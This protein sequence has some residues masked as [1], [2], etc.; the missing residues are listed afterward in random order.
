MNRIALN[1]LKPADLATLNDASCLYSQYL[2]FF[3]LSE[4]GQPIFI[5]KSIAVELEYL[6]AG[7]LKVRRIPATSLLNLE[8]HQGFVLQN[9]LQHYIG[10]TK[11]DLER[12]RSY[13][14]LERINKMLPV[15][16]EVN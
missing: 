3:A 2:D 5:Y 12:A 15:V 6:I 10:K 11:D 9:A 7:R 1:K 16:P 4:P 8:M 13:R 14:L